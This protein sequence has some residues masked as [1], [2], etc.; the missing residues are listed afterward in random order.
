MTDEFISRITAEYR[1]RRRHTSLNDAVRMA[2]G[3][4]GAARVLAAHHGRFGVVSASKSQPEMPK[5][6]AEPCMPHEAL[7]RSSAR[8]AS[9]MNPTGPSASMSRSTKTIARGP[10]ITR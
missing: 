3:R 7:A 4:A 5:K 1:A 8:S 2:P 6:F 10:A 9:Y